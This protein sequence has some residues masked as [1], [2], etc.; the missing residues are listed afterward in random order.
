MTHFLKVPIIR[1]KKEEKEFTIKSNILLLPA[2][3]MYI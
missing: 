2:R 1:E 3:L